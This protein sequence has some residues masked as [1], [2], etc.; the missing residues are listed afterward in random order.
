MLDQDQV[1]PQQNIKRIESRWDQLFCDQAQEPDQVYIPYVL[2]TTVLAWCILNDQMTKEPG[3]YDY[4][5]SV[6]DYGQVF[7]HQTLTETS[8]NNPYQGITPTSTHI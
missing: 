6:S 2:V 4:F 8:R 1:R 3:L 5:S 7:L